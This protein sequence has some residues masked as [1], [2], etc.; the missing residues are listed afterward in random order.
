M[1]TLGG[2]TLCLP[3]EGTVEDLKRTVEEREGEKFCLSDD[4]FLT[5]FSH[6]S[7]WYDIAMGNGYLLHAYGV[8]VDVL[9]CASPQIH[10][11]DCKLFSPVSVMQASALMS[12]AF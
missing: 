8:F 4:F 10:H 12:S 1:R 7:G 3:R 5:F 2:S 9:E 11:E 6:F